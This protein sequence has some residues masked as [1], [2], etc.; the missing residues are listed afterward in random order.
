VRELQNLLERVVLLEEGDELLPS[1][2]PPAIQRADGSAG[3]SLETHDPLGA[4]PE[5]WRRFCECTP[6]LRRNGLL[7]LRTVAD[8]YVAFVLAECDGNRSR[9]ARTLGISRQGLIDRLR[10]LGDQ[11]ERAAN[12][13][14]ITAQPRN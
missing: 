11:A 3:T 5:L 6:A 13:A 1:H 14:G 4:E 2:L 9:A 12:V 7:P 8:A 10:R